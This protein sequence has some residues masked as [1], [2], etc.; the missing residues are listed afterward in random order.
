MIDSHAAPMNDICVTISKD[1]TRFPGGRYKKH[2]ARSGEEFR[3]DILLPALR[4]G[5][6]VRVILDGTVGYPAS[7]LEEAFGGLVRRGFSSEEL[8]D[9]LVIDA[10]STDFHAYKKKAEQYI[11]EAE[12]SKTGT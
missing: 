12:S 2:G 7:F 5:A 11:K 4:A 1:F 3:E 10:I 8:S 6:R 9:L